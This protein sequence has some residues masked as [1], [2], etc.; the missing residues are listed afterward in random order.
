MGSEHS[1]ERNGYKSQQIGGDELQ[2][3]NRFTATCQRFVKRVGAFLFNKSKNRVITTD[4][5]F[6]RPG[7][8]LAPTSL[9]P[10]F[11]EIFKNWSEARGLLDTIEGV[12]IVLRHIDSTD[13]DKRIIAQTHALTY[14]VVLED[15]LDKVFSGASSEKERINDL[16]VSLYDD[17]DDERSKS[18]ELYEK[19][20][21]IGTP[22]A[23]Y[24]GG[25]A[26]IHVP[27]IRLELLESE[28][29]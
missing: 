5:P 23:I 25:S 8:R 16:L 9:Q 17:L 29:D 2:Q 13:L 28:E 26:L 7:D 1:N 3:E 27:D 11:E 19:P 24:E 21:I 10:R 22:F 20:L 6:R 18:Q 14:L 4:V 15:R 12:D